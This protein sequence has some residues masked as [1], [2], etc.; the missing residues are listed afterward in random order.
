MELGL[1]AL[2][3]EG[4]RVQFGAVE[5]GAGGGGGGEAEVLPEVEGANVLKLVGELVVE[6]AGFEDEF[7]ADEVLVDPGVE[8]AGALRAEGIDVVAGDIG[9]VAEGEQ[10]AVEGGKL[11]GE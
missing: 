6:V 2:G 3:A 1:E 7:L 5:E 8:G 4:L 11:G 9:G 10:G